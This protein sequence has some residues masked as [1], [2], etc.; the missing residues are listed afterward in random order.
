VGL[1]GALLF[2]AGD[3]VVPPAG[4]WKVLSLTVLPQAPTSAKIP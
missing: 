4:P 1:F 2:W 3:E